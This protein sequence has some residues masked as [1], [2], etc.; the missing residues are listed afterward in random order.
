MLASV[1][2]SE[3]AVKISIVIIKAFVRLRQI[4]STHKELAHKLAELEKKVEKHDTEIGAIFDA[5]R[6]LMAPPV[7]PKKK[8][9]FHRD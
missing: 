4:L 8:I 6:Q 7:K 2:K 3:K 1:L 5:I 9:G